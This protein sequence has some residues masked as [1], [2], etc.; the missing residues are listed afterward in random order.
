MVDE[1]IDQ[2]FGIQAVKTKLNAFTWKKMKEGCKLSYG[3][4]EGKRYLSVY[5][6][7]NT[8]KKAKLFVFRVTCQH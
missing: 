4:K 3:Y 5:R 8:E 2:G 1:L 6:F 7:F